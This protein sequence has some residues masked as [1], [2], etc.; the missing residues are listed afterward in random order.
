[1]NQNTL[2]IVNDLYNKEN[3]ELDKS[4][5]NFCEKNDKIKFLFLRS[6][7]RSSW[8]T[9]KEKLWGPD[10]E[11]EYIID[12]LTNDGKF[13]NFKFLSLPKNYNFSK[14]LIKCD[15]LAYSSNIYSMD[16]IDKLIDRL[17][18]KVLLHLSDERGRRPEF[19][20]VFRKV[21]LVYRQYNYTNKTGFPN[22]H[23]IKYL[24]LGYHSWGK[25]Y[26]RNNYL[27]IQSRK[28][29]WCFSGSIKNNRVSQVQQLSIIK[30]NF[31]GKTLP[32]ET[33]QMFQNSIFAFCPPGNSNIECSRIYE[34]MYNGCIP[35]ILCPNIISLKHF[36]N[37]FEI[38]LP[39]YFCVNIQDII[40]II[41]N[42]SVEN[43]KKKQSECFL[44]LKNISE[45][46]RKNILISLKI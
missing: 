21:K 25:K 3:T 27:D 42:T 13:S 6:E 7:S 18:P 23:F 32:F 5:Q 10:I 14:T 43:I 38:P 46:I 24:P 8:M 17:Q 15:I 29:K 40:N 9:D 2:H 19:I 16:F 22:K 45:S 31:Q 37:S 11:S 39:C 35:I 33:T 4:I 20:K 34:A 28:Y 41:Q 26:I 44:W 30:P 1:M 12:I 36:Q